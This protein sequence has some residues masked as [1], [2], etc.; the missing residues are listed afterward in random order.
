MSRCYYCHNNIENPFP[1]QLGTDT[2]VVS[3]CSEDCANKAT[4]FFEFFKRIKTLFCIVLGIIFAIFMVSSF[5]IIAAKFIG[6]IL[7]GS[8]LALM[9]LLFL[10]FPF[11]TPQT[12]Q[13]FGIKK[14]IW[15]TRII[16][17]ASIA[18]GYMIAVLLINS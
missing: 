1:V 8:S 6:S 4:A 13:I 10:L 2:M 5:I 16:S 7:M 12:F 18:L 9:G 3:C 15:I 14:T 11:A 17:I